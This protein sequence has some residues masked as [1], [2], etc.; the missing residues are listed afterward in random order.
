MS[1]AEFSV[2]RRVTVLMATATMVLFGLI[3]LFGLPVNLLPDLS[4]PTLTVR[5]EYT[6]AAPSEIE[7]LIT[8]PVEEAVGVVKGLRKL[9]SVSRTGQSDV[10]LEF[11][12]GT[13]MDRA[14]LEVRDKLET[15]RL[16]LEA[17]APVLLRFNPSTEPVMRLVL[18]DAGRS[19][20]AAALVA[21]RRYADEELKKQLEPVEGVAAVKAGGGLE[22]EIQVEIDQQKLA[23]LN[24]GIGTVIDRLRAEN[25]N[26]SGGRI[27]DGS[28]RYLVRT[29]NQFA[30]VDQIRDLLVT[31]RSTGGGDSAAQE[32]AAAAARVA[33]IT[34][35]AEALAASASA[36]S[37]A[38]GSGNAAAGGQA[39]RLRDVATITQGFKERES[40]I[41]LGGMEAVELAIYKEGDANTVSVADAVHESLERIRKELPAGVE[42]TVVDDQAIFIRQALA[43]VRFDAMLGGGLAILLIFFFLRDGWST[44]VISLSLPISLI[45]TFFF[46]DQLSLSLNVMSLGGLALATG[47]VVDDS[48]VVLESIAKARERGL[49][50]VEAAVAGTREVSMAVVASTLTNVAVFLPLVFV[51]GVAGQLFK[52]Q[53]LTISIAILMSLVVSLTLI[54]MLSSLKAKAPL[55]FPAEAP[56]PRWEPKNPALRAVASGRRGLGAIVG[57]LVF[58]LAWLVTTAFRGVIVPLGRGLSWLG[59]YVMLPYEW[60]ERRYARLLPAA[61]ARPGRVLGFAAAAFALSLALVPT[62]GLDMIPPLA[63]DRFEMT[64]KLPAGTQLR[65]TDAVLRAVQ[66]QHADEPGVRALYGVSGS[67]TR[68]DANPTESGEHIGKLTVVLGEG[69]TP[70]TE[71]AATASLRQTMATRFPGAEVKFGRPEIFSFSTPL[72][73]ELHGADLAELETAGRQ[74]VQLME[75]SDRFVDIKSTVAEGYPEIQIRF[76]QE[77]AAA[78]GLTTRQIA[79]QV[80]RKV[81]GEVATR[82]S[83]L[84]RKIDVLVRTQA[85]DRASVQDIRKLIVNPESAVP[86]TLD[87]VAEVIQTT[88]PGEIHHANQGRVAVVSA[89]LAY[90]DLG[91][92]VAEVQ[93]LVADNPLSG[94]VG[95][96]IGGQGEELAAS[97]ASLVFAFGL[98]IFLVYLV[99][100]SQFESLLHPFVIMFT[101]PLAMVGAVLALLVTRS[102]L[103]VVVFIGLILLVG[104]VVKNAILLIDKVNQLRMAGVPKHQALVEGASSRLRPIAMTSLTA[105]LG[106]LPMALATGEGAEVRAPMAATV[107]GGLAVSTLLTL[108]V[109]PVVYNLMDRRS[110]ESYVERARPIVIDEGEG[111]AEGAR[112]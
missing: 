18:A 91:S 64:V 52:D 81:R 80:V 47:L 45:A 101:I 102:S 95:L 33:A 103:S 90:G 77:R 23:R 89:G 53:A 72:E 96:R 60:A 108:V 112:A 56:A 51:E 61:L 70:A 40:I 27:E 41:R 105:L 19:E 78:L 15:L 44:F 6:G 37:A 68:L 109:I 50:I 79:D 59:H 55:A 87:S 97:V 99:M 71:A 12:W 24:L 63:Q 9:K 11:A 3:G 65:D 62:L 86:V 2:R 58:G 93:Q 21:L 49:G 32:A 36:Q 69:H 29:I 20:D 76:D 1:L 48:I 14:S 31:P 75:G 46:M 16:P 42:L 73:I 28:Q 38:S 17:E 110:D 7:T 4:Y 66:E 98:A 54:P 22:D 94:G 106:F 107:I 57:G 84:D 35:S 5:T 82:Y 10:V 111:E 83:F 30:D 74:L 85:A 13:D 104:I 25:V 67:G 39:V 88:G 43:D 8:E 34:G 26:I 100:A 92:A